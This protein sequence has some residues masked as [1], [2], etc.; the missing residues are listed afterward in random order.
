[1]KKDFLF[2]GLLKC[3]ECGHNLSISTRKTKKNIQ[4]WT[5][6][7]YYSKYSKYGMCTSHRLNYDL[8]EKDLLKFLKFAGKKFFRRL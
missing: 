7:N 4:H 3:K 8:L 6:C 1:M 2:Q 5:Q